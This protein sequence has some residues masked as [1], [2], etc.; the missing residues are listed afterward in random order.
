MSVGN[1]MISTTFEVKKGFAFHNKLPKLVDT[2][3]DSH[4]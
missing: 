1:Q 4:L 3:I 2:I